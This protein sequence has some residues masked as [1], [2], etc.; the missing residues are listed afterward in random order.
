V[1]EDHKAAVPAG[2]DL[3]Q[4]APA[5]VGTAP[6]DGTAVACWHRR[7]HRINGKYEKCRCDECTTS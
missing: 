1:R 5:C 2:G 6:A 7:E 4:I 3:D